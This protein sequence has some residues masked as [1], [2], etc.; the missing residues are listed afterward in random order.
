M[1][2]IFFILLLLF[3]WVIN[4]SANSDYITDYT[5]IDCIN[6]DNDSWVAFD[7][8]KS[9][10][11]LK[12]W[13]EK[14]IDYINTKVNKTWNE[15]TASW[16]IFNIKVKCS[17]EDLEN[18]RIDLDFKGTNF[19][20]KVIIEWIDNGSL[21]IK[22]SKFRLLKGAWNII[23]K[24]AS[25]LNDDMWYFEDQV[26]NSNNSRINP[27]SNWITIYNSYFKLNNSNQLWITNS[28]KYYRYRDLWSNYYWY[29]S[30]Y[31]N[32]L[33]IINSKIDVKLDWSYNFKMPFFLNNSKINFLNNTSSWIYDISFTENWNSSN[34]PRL[35]YSIFVSNEIDMWG[36]NLSI[37]N[38]EDITFLNNKIVNFNNIDLW[39]KGVFINNFIENNSSLDITKYINLF[40]NIFKSNYV[41]NNDIH[42]Y[43]RNFSLENIWSWGI[44][45]IYKRVRNFV[46]WNI[47]INSADLFKEVTWK[48]SENWLG[49]IYVIFSY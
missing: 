12:E 48:D 20:N 15:E 28:Y 30:N 46:F 33:K 7:S 13:I 3:L 10:S 47:D 5:L 36:N 8:L 25:F 23:I 26:F 42:N 11:T 6:W 21:V 41:D 2:K 29:I 40:N 1:K 9:Y 35:D 44:W 4:V 14:T 39:W 31:F 32:K 19:N 45:W 43:R 18:P 49:D 34:F 24:N 17:F 22:N 27:I 16:I 38:D 37:E